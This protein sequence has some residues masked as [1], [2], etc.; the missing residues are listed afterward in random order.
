[1][2]TSLVLAGLTVDVHRKHLLLGNHL[3]P[4]L[5]GPTDLRDGLHG[6]VEVA[7]SHE[8]ASKERINLAISLEV[9]HI[10]GEV[11]C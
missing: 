7:G 8:V 3:P 9:V 11:D 1:M 5:S 10:K 2:E 4:L 6:G